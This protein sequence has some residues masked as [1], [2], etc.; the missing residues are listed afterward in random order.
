MNDGFHWGCLFGAWIA[1]IFAFL[2]GY[3]FGQR[4]VR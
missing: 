4:T 1:M 2:A 3:R